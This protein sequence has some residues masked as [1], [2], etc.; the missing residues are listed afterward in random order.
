MCLRILSPTVVLLWLRLLRME[1]LVGWLRQLGDIQL[2]LLD[3]LSFDRLLLLVRL[4][5][6]LFD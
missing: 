4:M 6:F 2:P 1:N 3:A 5:C